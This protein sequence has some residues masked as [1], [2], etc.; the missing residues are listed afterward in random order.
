MASMLI[1]TERAASSLHA[2][3]ADLEQHAKS[4]HYKE[5]P[6]LGMLRAIEEC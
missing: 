4:C 3:L 6:M 2:R 1:S 5:Y